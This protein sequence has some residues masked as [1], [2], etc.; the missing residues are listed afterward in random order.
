MAETTFRSNASLQSLEGPRNCGNSPYWLGAFA[1]RLREPITES[2]ILSFLVT[3]VDGENNCDSMWM[4]IEC[5]LSSTNIKT[6]RAVPNWISLLSTRCG[7]RGSF[8]SFYSKTKGILHKLTKGNLI[9]AKDDNFE[10]V[11]Y[12]H[13]SQRIA[14]G[15]KRFP[16]GH[17]CHIT[18]KC[19]ISSTRT[20]H[21]TDERLCDTTTQSSAPAIV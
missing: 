21:T 17:K 16:T 4:R 14:D 3:Q 2:N 18:P 15:S 19:S 11:L 6:A 20:F 9:A 7:D 5:H 8:L 12:G 1:S 10:G 13:R